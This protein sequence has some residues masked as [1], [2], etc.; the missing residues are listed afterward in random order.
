VLSSP[1]VPEL[2]EVETVRRSLE[3][4]VV[5]RRVERVEARR[6]RLRRGIDPRSW[7]TRVV[8][9]TIE[10]LDRRGKY[11]LLEFDRTTAIIHLGMS[12][13]LQL[14]RLGQPRDPH[15]HLVLGFERGVELRFVDPRRFGAAFVVAPGRVDSVAELAILGPDPVREDVAPTLQAAAARSRTPIRNLLLDQHVVAGLGNIYANEA[16][17]RAGIHPLR[18]ADTIAW[19]RIARLAT[20]IRAVL[21]DALTAGGTTLADGGFA[22]AAG[23]SG[24][25]AVQLSVY[26][27]EGEPCPRCGSTVRRLV[28]GNRSV[29]FCPRCQR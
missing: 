21:E 2:P 4:R 1:A 27:R 10:R 3:P 25:F 7:R 18:R 5:G 8:G 13:R 20:E 24:Y 22:D 15:T 23:A 16:L 26:G 12:G 6:V 9:A 14:A 28:A 19:R 17:A 11:L 29:F